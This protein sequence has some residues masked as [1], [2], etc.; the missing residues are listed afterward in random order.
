MFARSKCGG[1]CAAIELYVFC[2]P[3][4]SLVQRYDNYVIY[5]ALREKKLWKNVQVSKKYLSLQR[6]NIGF[7]YLGRIPRGQ[8]FTAAA[9]F[10]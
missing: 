10:L 4:G 2:V 5:E 7:G 8:D 9:Q 6:Q 3:L 1:D